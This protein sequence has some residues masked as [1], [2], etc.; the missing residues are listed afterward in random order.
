MKSPDPN[1][2]QVNGATLGMAV[3]G[4]ATLGESS[5]KALTSEMSVG[6]T[7]TK[8]RATRTAKSTKRKVVK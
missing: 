1:P 7:S 4:K 6:T 3:L 8:K 2:P 5:A